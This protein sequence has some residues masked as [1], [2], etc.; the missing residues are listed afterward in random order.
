[1]ACVVPSLV[2]T[3]VAAAAEA[4]APVTLTSQASH[5][6][7]AHP[8]APLTDTATLSGGD[9]PQG[10]MVFTIF[11][12]DDPTCAGQPLATSTPL[13]V[14]GPGTFT[15][16]PFTP[17]HSG[18]YRWIANYS[19]DVN[20]AP[21]STPCGDPAETVVVPTV[22]P[23]FSTQATPLVGLGNAISDS[24]FL[25]V[26]GNASGTISF[27][28]FSPADATCVAPVF[29]PPPVAVS[30]SGTYNS[31]PFT[32][33]AVGLYR[34]IATYSGDTDNSPVAGA[35]HD[36]AEAS[37]VIP[38]QPVTISTLASQP[39]FDNS[40]V[41]SA[42]LSGGVSPTG[43]VTFNLY[44][45]DD[46][47]CAGPPVFTSP[48]QLL[49]PSPNL[50]ASNIFF[51]VAPGTYRWVASYSGDAINGPAIGLCGDPSE[52]V[53]VAPPPVATL[54]TQASGNV[55]AGGTLT[56]S[57]T[58]SVPGTG[59]VTGII[60]FDL[61]GPD[62]ATCSGTP[63]FTS[64]VPISARGSYLSAPFTAV[65]PGTYRWVATYSGDIDNP[66]IGPTAC[67]D[68]AESTV[69]LALPP[70]VITQASP[71]I[72]GQD[73]VD[74]ASLSG[75]LNPTGTILFALYGPDIPCTGTPAFVS[76]VTVSGD[77]N[78]TSQPFFPIVPGTYRW[79][80]TYSGDV[81]N[82]AFGPTPCDAPGETVVVTPP[83]PVSLTTHAFPAGN[84][85]N[86]TAFLSGGTNPTGT[87]TFILYGPSDATCSRPS[88][89]T[90]TKVATGPGAYI[91]DVTDALRP[92][93]YRWVA[94][95]SGDVNNPAVGP[96]PCGDPSETVVIKAPRQGSLTICKAKK[97]GAKGD[98]TFTVEDRTVTVAA[99]QC[100]PSIRVLAGDVTVTEVPSIGY[101]LANC[102]TVPSGRLVACHRQAGQA[103]VRVAAGGIAKQTIVTFT[104]RRASG[105]LKVCKVAG[106]GVAQGSS[107]SFLVDGQRV[108]VKAGAAPGGSCAIAGSFPVGTQV[109]VV[110]RVKATE[111]VSAIV[112]RPA[113]R[114][115][116]T[117]DLE[118]GKVTVG[119]ATG[120]TEVTFTD[121]A[122]PAIA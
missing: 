68:P 23:D 110:E 39:Q 81:D 72:P 89:F 99:G 80:A 90:S 66:A 3:T 36:P 10:V 38:T 26:N 12:P 105:T 76:L 42:T 117:P 1:M 46:P 53:F 91:S 86:D 34:W 17:F 112:V 16:D 22:A 14:F 13:G 93:T 106:D 103:V 11:G 104:N 31:G 41:D 5:P 15:S 119:M 2:L 101:A 107:H 43:V 115:V 113:D 120:V 51:P 121:V 6:D 95:Y 57:A 60:T 62:D 92:G 71:F 21:V 75:G 9:N 19:G 35:C 111:R 54:T 44:G 49:S 37:R 20:N 59:G 24:A 84:G 97:N 50:Y 32:P 109:D 118:A 83:P 61:F 64:A 30:G 116:G 114:V 67:D 73:I 78:Y 55:P 25:G 18:T 40:L 45:P 108:V 28:L 58:L 8:R 98:F 70:V 77:G 27:A 96:T 69:V 7:P 56:D 4:P 122:R 100:S 65:A 79:V 48:G 29:A 74:T 94:G 102:T 52:T 33:T 63:A 87:I 82:A 85:L 88:I 47:S